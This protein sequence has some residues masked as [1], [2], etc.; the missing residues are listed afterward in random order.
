M[1]R[2]GRIILLSGESGLG[3]TTLC[4][5]LLE[6]LKDI[7]LIVNGVVCPPLYEGSIKSGIEVL[8][9][10]SNE[11]RQLARLNKGENNG[12][13]TRKWL[14]D[15]TVTSWGNQE[16]AKATPCDV[17]VIDELG[18]LE[19]ERDS[20]FLNAFTAINSRDYRSALVVI[21]PSLLAKAIEHWPDAFAVSITSETRETLLHQVFDLLT[22]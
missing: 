15:E 8:I 20:G 13:F 18:P 10:K 4:L 3:K 16:L 19:F 14:F 9:L 21:R 5:K 7:P 1:Q 17:L 22:Q 6:M 2:Q 12:L 11:K